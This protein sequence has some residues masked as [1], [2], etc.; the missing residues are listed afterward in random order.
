MIDGVWSA[1]IGFVA[2]SN[3]VGKFLIL[4]QRFCHCHMFILFLVQKSTSFHKCLFIYLLFEYVEVVVS[5][6]LF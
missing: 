6:A 4:T 2:G 1:T 5:V 3:R